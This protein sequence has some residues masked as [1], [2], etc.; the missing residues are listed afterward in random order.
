MGL[1]MNELPR[2]ATALIPSGRERFSAIRR[3]IRPVASGNYAAPR[4]EVAV[5]RLVAITAGDISGYSRLM[6]MDEEGTFDRVKRIQRELIEPAIADHHGR[7][8][9][10]TGDGF[11]AIFDSPV[12]AVRCAILIQQNM[13]ERNRSVPRQ[14]WIVYRIGV[15]LGDVIVEPTDVHGEGV[16]VAVRLEGIATPGEVYI[17]GGVYEQ[18][19][20]KLFCGYQSLGDRQVKNIT[21]P[22]RVYRV[23]PEPAAIASARRGRP[24]VLISVLSAALLATAGGLWH[25]VTQPGTRVTD[26]ALAPAQMAVATSKMPPRFLVVETPTG[27]RATPQ[28]ATAVTPIASQSA[29]RAVGEPE[30]IWIPGGSFAMG[31]NDDVSEG[32]IHQVSI[33]PVAISKFPITVREWNQCVAAHACADLAVGG[34]E[35]PIT[36]VSWADAK[37]FVAWLTQTTHKGYRLPSE[38]EWEYAARGGTRTKYWWGDRL[39]SGMANCRNCGDA[40]GK[41]KPIKVG[42]FKPNQFGLHDM[43]GT[44]DQWVE[45]CWHTNY[46]GAPLD[47]SPWID[48]DCGSRV[49]RSGSWD[50]DAT[51]VRPMNRDHYD[52]SVRYPTHGFRVARSP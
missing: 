25:V 19:R 44:V 27:A 14:H 13:V 35:A 51:Y 52:V 46:H 43:G 21:D 37:Q 24:V 6:G 22:V 10:T 39:L 12:E 50:N 48:G 34:D 49:I 23:L 40:A 17:S 4:R 5:R 16:N 31:S 33:E 9:K 36:N 26:K 18:I 3:E 32:P 29:S 11:I 15:N 20:N 47:G 38:A 41:D 30:M 2:K 28:D 8:V 42:S 7:M 45:D 1:H